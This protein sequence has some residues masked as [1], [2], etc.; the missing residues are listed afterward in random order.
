VNIVPVDIM[1]PEESVS[2]IQAVAQTAGKELSV[3]EAKTLAKKLGNDPILIGLFGR[4][5]SSTDHGELESHTENVIG[6]FVRSAISEVA[7]SSDA[8][9]VE[10]DYKV[11]L[12][13]LSTKMLMSRNIYPSW[14]DVQTWF[15]GSPEPLR[16]LI[17][18]GKLFRKQTGDRHEKL[19]FRHDR[20]RDALLVVMVHDIAAIFDISI[21]HQF[22]LMT[23]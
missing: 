4:L 2:A 17:A 1:T 6:E 21:R 12:S 9:L 23:S 15:D 19:T 7:A 3:L 16:E 22:W 20:I 8:R 11:A 18:H 14:E 13:T 5:M 10:A